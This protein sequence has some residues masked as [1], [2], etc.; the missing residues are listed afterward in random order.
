MQNL[1]FKRDCGRAKKA[2]GSPEDRRNNNFCAKK[3]AR[4]PCTYDIIFDIIYMILYMILYD[5][6]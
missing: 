5:I 1:K 3:I 4:P 2:Q 6:I